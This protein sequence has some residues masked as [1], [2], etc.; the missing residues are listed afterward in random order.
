MR[1]PLKSSPLPV[2]N[3]SSQ[4]PRSRSVVRVLVSSSLLALALGTQ[5]GCGPS[6]QAVHVESAADQSSYAAQYPTDLDALS[7]ELQQE[8]QDARAVMTGWDAVP[9]ELGQPK[10]TDL[11][12]LFTKADQ[13]GKS[14][15]YANARKSTDA[16]RAFM[17]AEQGEITKKV[18]GY[19]DYAAKQKGHEGSDLGNAAMAGVKEAVD[20]RIEKRLRENNEAT[21]LLEDEKGAIDKATQEKIQKRLDE[22]AQASYLVHVA[23]PETR[24]RLRDKQAEGDR[25]RQTL[26][27]AVEDAKK[28]AE[29]ATRPAEARKASTQRAEELATAQKALDASL[30]RAKT[31]LDQ[32][33]ARITQ[34]SKDYE[35]KLEALKQ[36]LPTG[37]K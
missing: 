32:A 22:T 36:K 28:R 23:V 18:V 20:K 25:V 2:A 13:S 6:N 17:R 35:D 26:A 33:E 24:A 15:G 31:G 10:D 21:S 12:T 7:E 30:G 16:V 8:E 29:D 19:V 27:R 5:V 1:S 4:S 34:L 11:R 9:A 14:G 37:K 3:P